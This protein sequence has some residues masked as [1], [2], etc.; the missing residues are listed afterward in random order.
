MQLASALSAMGFLIWTARALGPEARGVLAIFTA[1]VTL[2]IGI[3]GLGV[4]HAVLHYS[5]RGV[6]F[7]EVLRQV[8]PVLLLGSLLAI[9]GTPHLFGLGVGNRRMVSAWSALV[10]VAVLAAGGA[11][12]L[13]WFALGLGR[14]SYVARARSVSMVASLVALTMLARLHLLTPLSAASCWTF[15]WVVYVLQLYHEFR[16]FSAG[17]AVDGDVFSA[18]RFA[19]SSVPSAMGDSLGSRLDLWL[20]GL[21]SAHSVAGNYSVALGI[22]EAILLPAQA[23]GASLFAG[24][25]RREI[26]KFPAAPVSIALGL[27]VG[28]S[29]VVTA[30]APWGV[31]AIFGASYGDAIM[32]TVVLAGGAV[33]LAVQRAVGPYLAG[34]GYPAYLSGASL[35]TAGSLAIAVIVLTPRYGAL[36]AACG[37]S[38]AYVVGTVFTLGSLW[39]LRSRAEA[40]S[41]GREMVPTAGSRDTVHA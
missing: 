32:P 13:Q 25:S 37:S 16:P 1:T 9:V 2:S 27:S 40:K 3:C 35:V 18:R 26:E 39:R 19:L 21:V 7:L 15:M 30:L 29:V 28:T 11:T 6:G 24:A 12:L 38:I 4:P 33:F 10:I 17:P 36:G 31:R 14:F 22:S 34:L 5:G 20:V 8:R 23:L 41:C